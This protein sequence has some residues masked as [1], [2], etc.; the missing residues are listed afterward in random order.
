MIC[1]TFLEVDATICFK[2]LRDFFGATSP[3]G[4]CENIKSPSEFHYT[5]TGDETILNFFWG[6]LLN[7][8]MSSHAMSNMNVRNIC[9]DENRS[10]NPPNNSGNGHGNS[11]GN[12]HGNG[13]GNINSGNN[14]NGGN[15]GR[16]VSSN[17]TRQ[18]TPRVEGRQYGGNINR[19]GREY[20]TFLFSAL[21]WN[22]IYF[23]IFFAIFIIVILTHFISHN[24]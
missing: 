8:G 20:D 17:N 14:G 21:L 12:G 19:C 22:D 24:K 3:S 23:F 4:K 11:H 15:G 13:H 5:Y 9:S 10:Y 18:T 16:D 1:S 2:S 6:K 7:I